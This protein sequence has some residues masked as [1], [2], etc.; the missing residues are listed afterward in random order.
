MRSRYTAFA[1]GAIDWIMDSHHPETV[2]EID[3]D[4]VERWA[5]GSEWLGLRIRDTEAGGPDD[6]EG[7]VVFR[8]RYK[9]QAQ[10]V[11]HVERAQFTRDGTEWR[12]HS[13]LANDDQPELVA[14]APASTVGRNDPCPCGSGSKYKKCCGAAA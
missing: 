2:D 14:V 8:A 11:D 9:V 6:D 12:F 3:R 7:I 5:N 4:E 13:V 1:T 10:Q